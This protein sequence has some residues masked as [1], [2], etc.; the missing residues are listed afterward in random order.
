MQLKGDFGNMKNKLCSI[1]FCVAVFFFI[2]T[3]S[4][5]LPI[6]F[7][8]FYYLHIDAMDIP[9][10]SGFAKEEI[11]DAYN[12][13]LDYLTIPGKEFGTGVMKY[14]E[15]GEAHFVDCKV[16]FDLNATVLVVS[17]VIII[18][19]LVLFKLK[20]IER[21]RIGKCSSEF[22]SA[23]AAIVLPLVL[24]GL[25]A[26]DFDK[27]FVVFHRIF[28]PGKDNWLFDYYEDEIIRVLPQDFFMNCAI[29]IACGVLVISLVII[30][31]EIIVLI[32]K[33]KNG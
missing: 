27:A 23:V 30:V 28:F 17:A 32:K 31:K 18:A 25:A 1:L 4:I 7:R 20:K 15:S 3:F 24:G 29:L 26:I 13:M 19:L 2:I 22:W 6:Y 21:P 11:L 10:K 9:E 16:L 33:Q 14:S 8:P 5:G 12:E